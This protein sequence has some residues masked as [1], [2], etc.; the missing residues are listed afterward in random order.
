M[1]DYWR[2]EVRQFADDMEHQLRN[3]DRK[4]GWKHC[5]VSWLLSRAKDEIQEIIDA[6]ADADDHGAIDECADAA[7][8]LMMASDRIKD[9]LCR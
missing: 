3:N 1:A 7:N 4:T 9:R 8:F 5:K 6:L 2:K